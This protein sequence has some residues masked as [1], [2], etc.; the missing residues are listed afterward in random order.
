MFYVFF[1]FLDVIFYIVFYIELLKSVRLIFA[2]IFLCLGLQSK[3]YML[4]YKYYL[5][6][7][8]IFTTIKAKN[9]WLKKK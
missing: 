7:K 3:K 6:C 1:Y 2:M 4:I 8:Y 5:D 9:M